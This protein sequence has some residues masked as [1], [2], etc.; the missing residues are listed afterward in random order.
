MNPDLERTVQDALSFIPPHDRDTWYRMAAAIKSA[1][2]EDG[3]HIWDQ[4]SRQDTRPAPHG[5]VERN[6][7]ATWKSF[8][9]EGK[10]TAGTLFAVAKEWGWSP[11]TE[12][13]I[14]VVEAKQEPTPVSVDVER[15]AK[16]REAASLAMRMMTVAPMRPHPYLESKG[17]PTMEWMVTDK[18]IH[19]KLLPKNHPL[20]QWM[21]VG[22]LLLIPMRSLRNNSIQSLQFIGPD[23]DKKFL[24]GGRATNAVYRIGPNP[25]RGSMWYCEGFATGVAIMDALRT[26]GRRNDQV[27]VCFSA[28]GMG[29]IAQLHQPRFRGFVVADHDEYICTKKGCNH[30]WDG[31]WGAKAC[32]QCKSARI[33]PP[34]GEKAAV[35]SGLPYYLP[36]PKMDAYDFATERG[37]DALARELRALAVY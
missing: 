31:K 26:V 25:P 37:I 29:K 19:F 1:L 4:W 33:L 5:Y 21:E 23:G 2:G 7:Q 12:S 22:D 15:E 30:R 20:R 8:R 18:D 28:G 24:P 34:A 14:K 17:W 36:P 10:I 35:E 16:A 3:F 32:P 13:A 27:V 6:A 11:R 9:P